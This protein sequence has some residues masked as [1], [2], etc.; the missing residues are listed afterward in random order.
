MNVNPLDLQVLF[1]KAIDHQTNIQKLSAL[2]ENVEHALNT[3]ST[4]HSK[5]AP[6]VV[7]NTEDYAEEFTTVD[8]DGT[9][10]AQQQAAGHQKNDSGENDG[11]NPD[12]HVGLIDELAGHHVDIID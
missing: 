11:Q 3:N 2:N 10:N 9:N 12:S 8:K 5:D 1:S 4:Q 6:D 7:R